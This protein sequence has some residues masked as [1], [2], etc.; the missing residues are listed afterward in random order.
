MS[1]FT[2]IWNIFHGKKHIVLTPGYKFEEIWL[3]GI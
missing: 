1:N 2:R 3:R